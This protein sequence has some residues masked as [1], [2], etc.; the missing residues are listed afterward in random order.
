ME[1][2]KINS[3]IERKSSGDDFLPVSVSYR[4]FNET[5]K[6]G[7]KLK[8]YEN[9]VFLPVSSKS[10]HKAKDPLHAYNRTRN[11]KLPNG[12][13]KKVHLDF[14]TSVNDYQIIL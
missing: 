3:L 11:F 4:T 6:S 8:T 2:S 9:A 10:T 1:L 7:G 5:A 12:E 13:L 14:I